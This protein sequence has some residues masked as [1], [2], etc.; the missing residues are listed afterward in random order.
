M[1]TLTGIG[2]VLLLRA[3]PIGANDEIAVAREAAA[4]Q[5]LQPRANVRR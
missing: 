4:S 2:A 3:K 1:K 5:P